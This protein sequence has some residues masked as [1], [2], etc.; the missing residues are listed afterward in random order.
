MSYT[1]IS[2]LNK[3]KKLHKGGTRDLS[4]KP[5]DCKELSYLQ[6]YEKL[7]TDRQIKNTPPPP[8]ILPLE[9]I[10]QTILLQDI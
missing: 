9:D 3:H 8:N 1:S 5:E 4:R 7:N 6:K 10:A 2:V